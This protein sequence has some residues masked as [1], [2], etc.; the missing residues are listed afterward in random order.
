M[1]AL[2]RLPTYFVGTLPKPYVRSVM[3]YTFMIDQ[4]IVEKTLEFARANGCY[5]AIDP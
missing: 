4:R 5:P 3:S 2:Q 1:N